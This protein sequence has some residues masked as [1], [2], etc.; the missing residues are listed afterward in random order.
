MPSCWYYICVR[1]Y[2]TWMYDFFLL[3]YLTELNPRTLPYLVWIPWLCLQLHIVRYSFLY[4]LYLIFISYNFEFVLKFSSYYDFNIQ[5]MNQMINMIATYDEYDGWTVRHDD[6]I[7]SPLQQDRYF[8]HVVLVT[9]WF[10]CSFFIPRLYLLYFGL[11]HSSS[12]GSKKTIEL[13][14]NY[15]YSTC[16]KGYIIC[17]VNSAFFFTRT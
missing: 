1:W 9:Y 12:M 6:Q 4:N 5:V 11:L 15:I 17:N 7:V 14:K 3:K 16:L 2:V 8:R 10:F 13:T